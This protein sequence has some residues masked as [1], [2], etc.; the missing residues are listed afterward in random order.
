MP[1]RA[2]VINL[3]FRTILLILLVPIAA[4]SS[5]DNSFT[6]D[7]HFVSQSQLLPWLNFWQG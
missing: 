2:C 5:A 1:Q 4:L 3:L 6:V 7:E